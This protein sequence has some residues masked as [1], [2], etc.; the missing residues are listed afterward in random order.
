MTLTLTPMSAIPLE[1]LPLIYLGG[2]VD[3]AQ[4]EHDR[5]WQ[6]WEEWWQVGEPYCPKCR[7]R[8]LPGDKIIE[9]NL[10]ALHQA[11]YCVLDLRSYSIGTPIEMYWRAWLGELPAIIIHSGSSVF[12]QHVLSI[13]PRVILV[14]TPEEALRSLQEGHTAHG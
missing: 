8:G 6:H 14:A 12:V 5:S 13:N 2:A 7:C 1:P 4:G 10:E 3:A 11:K 9:K